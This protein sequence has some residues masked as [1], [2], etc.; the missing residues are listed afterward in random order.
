V[1]AAIG[2][3]GVLVALGSAAALAVQGIRAASGA[4]GRDPLRLPVYGIVAGAAVAM[5]ALEFALLTHDFSIAYVVENH[6]RATPFLFTVASAWAA[7]EGSIVLWG[8]VLAG[9]TL[10]VFHRTGREDRL[11]AGA[12]AVMGLVAVFFFGLMATA[13]N[14]FTTVA[15]VPADGLG[16]NPLLQNNLLMAVHPPLLYL[17]FIGFTVP[18]AFAMSALGLGVRGTAWLERTHRWSLVAWVFLTAGIAM[19]AL[20]SYAVLGW[21]GYWA[22]DPVENASFLP[23]LVG[24]AFIH[25]AVVQRRRGMLQAWNVALVIGT[26][27]LTILGTFLTR[28]GV[29]NSVHSFTQSAVGP[30]LLA[31][32]GVVIVASFALFAVR[33]HLVASPPRLESFLSREGFFLV[34]NLLLTIFAFAVL[35]GTIYPLLVE[36][37]TGDQLSVGRPFF[38][39]I[40]IPLGFALLLAMGIGP[41]TP[42]RAPRPETV[43]A[44]IRT[45]LR[46]GLVAGAAAVLAGI[47]EL[48]AVVMIVL[49]VFVAGTIGRHLWTTARAR[50]EAGG[51]TGRAAWQAMRRDPGFWGGQIAHIGLVVAAVGITMSGIYA[52]RAT[53]GLEPG[54]SAP[55]DGYTLTYEAPFSRDEDHRSIVGASIALDRG[56][57]RLAVLRPTLNQFENFAQPVPSP[58]IRVGLAEDVYVSLVRIDTT[59]ITVDVFRHPL[60][61]MLWAGGAIVVA[62]ALWSLAMR[63]PERAAPVLRERE[64]GVA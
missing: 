51:S 32:L 55:F 49:A 14:P 12:L 17:G 30:A 43:W 20:W 62:G 44:R 52:S 40:A 56:D 13:A 8:L 28:S 31:F 5:G 61:W 38:D 64:A 33:A 53:I 26:F 3:A 23:W 63:K 25:S 6:T 27:A 18:Y 9:F 47:R 39:R 35:M 4:A 24:T 15:V 60:I 42:W 16:P 41:V 7:L 58:A 36:A 59:A 1:T 48:N 19:G 11:A 50:R 22:W 46:A 21:G 57:D 2:Y 45:P 10:W 54:E 29:I 34:N 37:F